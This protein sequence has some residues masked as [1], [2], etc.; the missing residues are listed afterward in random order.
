[1]QQPT[2]DKTC[3]L[4]QE[5]RY[6]RRIACRLCFN[7]L[8][9]E[10][11]FEKEEDQGVT[12]CACTAEDF[13]WWGGE[14][15]VQVFFCLGGGGRERR[16]CSGLHTSLH[17]IPRAFVSVFVCIVYVCVCVSLPLSLARPMALAR[18]GSHARRTFLRPALV[19]TMLLTRKRLTAR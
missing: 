4:G 2:G 19:N 18:Q 5:H 6:I 13:A 17:S 7:G 16:G 12:T 14:C 11:K 9:H 15:R 8:D 10:P 3:L 1:M